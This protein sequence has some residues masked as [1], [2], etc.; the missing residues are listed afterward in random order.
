MAVSPDGTKL[1]VADNLKN[2]V[3]VIDLRVNHV[4]AT[5][6]IGRYPYTVAVSPDMLGRV[7]GGLAV[8]DLSQRV[9]GDYAGTFG[10]VKDDAN[11]TSEKLAAMI[12]DV[13]RLAAR[14]TRALP[15]GGS[16]KVS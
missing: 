4:V 3:S 12:E 6:P 11:A 8:G 2:T 5:I 16:G 1:L 14:V 15:T 7:L 10:K 9:S 13:G